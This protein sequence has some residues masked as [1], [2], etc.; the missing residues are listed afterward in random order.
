MFE[1]RSEAVPT[2]PS[3]L[4]ADIQGPG[5]KRSP[6]CVETWQSRVLESVMRPLTKLWTHPNGTRLADSSSIG[7][8]RQAFSVDIGY[9]TVRK[10]LRLSEAQTPKGSICSVIR[11][12][13]SCV[14]RR[15]LALVVI[16]GTV[17][18]QNPS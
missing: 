18:Y 15:R 3:A 5:K 14:P 17:A 7:P 10:D 13:R 16:S 2:P 11:K 12:G 1:H 9:C 8:T 4:D 6:P